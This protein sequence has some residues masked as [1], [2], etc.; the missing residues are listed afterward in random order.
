MIYRK[1]KLDKD[2]LRRI[3][4]EDKKVLKI[5][6]EAVKDISEVYKL[7]VKDGYYPKGIKKSELEKAGKKSSEV[8]SPFTYVDKVN[9]KLIVTPFY[10]KYTKLLVPIAKKIE[11]AAKVCS[12]RS[13][14]KYLNARAKSL[15]DGSYRESDTI[16]FDVKGSNIDFYI[17]PAER[18]L[19]KLFFIKRAF[20]A[21]AGAIDLN[22]TQKVEQIREALYSSAKISPDKYHS[23]NIPKKG[24][25]IY[26]ENTP[27]TAGYIA[28]VL[29]SGEHFP[30][31]LDIMQKQGSKIIFYQDQ[32][33]LKFE[34]LYYPIFKLIFEK[35]FSAKYDKEL[36]RRATLYNIALYEMGRQ[37]HKFDGARERLKELY[38]IIDEANGFA[39][40]IQHSKHLVV[41]GLIS[42]D[43]LEAI[44]IIHI[45][46]M[47]AD[48]LFY[49]HN[50]SVESYVIANAIC[51]NSYISTEGLK[52]KE[53]IYWP[54]FSKMF[55]E[56][57]ELADNLVYLLREGTFEEAER[58]AEKHAYLQSFEKLSKNLDKINV[59]L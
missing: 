48:W 55:F 14:S 54:N 34:K 47:F 11:S 49:K 13:F 1:F 53:G 42:Q 56:I 3:S 7:Q 50:K 22:E 2:I 33:E 9:G 6:E 26:V 28:D 10:Q 12:N 20:Q 17:G 58:F 40:G 32:C 52:E 21:Y 44:I 46:W 38:G 36:L 29:F 16:W 15:I 51:L 19:D 43:E 30:S 39:S 31:D 24:V 45:I 8:L 18:Y 41:K 27:S 25:R 59:T 35:R 37:L 5:L 4:E 23:T 57:E